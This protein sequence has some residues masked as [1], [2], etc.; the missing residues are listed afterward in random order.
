VA[1]CGAPH[2]WWA[3]CLGA[4]VGV[5]VVCR[6]GRRG[7]VHPHG[8]RGKHRQHPPAVE[9]TFLN[10]GEVSLLV[11]LLHNAIEEPAQFIAFPV[12]THADALQFF[13][14]IIL[15]HTQLVYHGINHFL[16]N[17][18]QRFRQMLSAHGFGRSQSTPATF[19]K[20]RIGFLEA[21]RS[22]D[23]A[24]V[25]IVHTAVLV[26]DG[27]QGRE[28]GLGKFRSFFQYRIHQFAVGIGNPQLCEQFFR[29]QY[30]EQGKLHVALRGGVIIQMNSSVSAGIRS[31]RARP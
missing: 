14:G 30:I 7:G 5:W 29:F 2:A 21:G 23:R 10:I 6:A 27:V 1:E 17:C 20:L 12:Q 31:D 25:F 9:K 28:Y 18:T 3:R 16:D 22:R 19:D 24:S 13:A 11:H 8:E 15:H 26:T 4:R